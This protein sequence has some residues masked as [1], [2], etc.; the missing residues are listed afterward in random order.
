MAFCIKLAVFWGFS[1]KIQAF[2]F[3]KT[4]FFLQEETTFSLFWETLPIQLHPT[5]NFLSLAFFL[6]KSIVF[7]KNP[8]TLFNKTK[9]WTFQEVL[10]FQSHFNASLLSSAIFSKKIDTFLQKT[11]HIFPSKNPKLERSENF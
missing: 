5:T 1:K 3:E 11:H 2:F 4:I 6:K 7:S 8:F 9:V 10:L